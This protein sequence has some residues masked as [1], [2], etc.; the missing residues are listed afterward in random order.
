[1]P[2]AAAGLPAPTYEMTATTAVPNLH[3]VASE[4][5]SPDRVTIVPPV[6]GPAVGLTEKI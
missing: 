3:P 4:R 5:S 1:M 6:V 2:L